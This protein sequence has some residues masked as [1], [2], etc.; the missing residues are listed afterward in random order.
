MATVEGQVQVR[1]V[2][3]GCGSPCDLTLQQCNKV[4]HIGIVGFDTSI[5]PQTTSKRIIL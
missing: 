4:I 5:T 1:T 2:L 3:S